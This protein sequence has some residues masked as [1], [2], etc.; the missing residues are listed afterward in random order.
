MAVDETE[1]SMRVTR[2]VGEIAGRVAGLSICLLHIYPEPSAV[3]MQNGL[4]PQDYQQK[5]EAIGQ[6]VFARS[7]T[8]LHSYGI[9]ADR[10]TAFCRM[11]AG[12]TISKTILLVQAEGG[13]GTVVVGKR[14][15]SKAEEFLF[16]SISNAVVRSSRDF[17]VWVVG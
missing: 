8:I 2:Y 1:T 13:Y 9:P 7:R 6:Q 3:Q 15:V 4:D 17:T 16:G 12:E 14:G 10:I 5:N 11:A